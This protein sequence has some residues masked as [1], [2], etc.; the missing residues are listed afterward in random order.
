MTIDTLDALSKTPAFYKLNYIQSLCDRDDP[1]I[2]KEGV[3]RSP[4]HA[5]QFLIL[6]AGLDGAQKKKT[7]IALAAIASEHGFSQRTITQA[8]LDELINQIHWHDLLNP[9]EDNTFTFKLNILLKNKK[10]FCNALNKNCPELAKVIFSDNKILT[11]NEHDQDTLILTTTVKQTEK[12]LHEFEDDVFHKSISYWKVERDENGSLMNLLF[13]LL[14]D[15]TSEFFKLPKDK[16]NKPERFQLSDEL[17]NRIEDMNDGDVCKLNEFVIEKGTGRLA[18]TI[19]ILIKASKDNEYKKNAQNP[20]PVNNGIYASFDNLKDFFGYEQVRITIELKNEA[21]FSKKGASCKQS[22]R[23]TAMDGSCGLA[24]RE[25]SQPTRIIVS[26]VIAN[27]MK[28]GVIVAFNEPRVKRKDLA[29][30]ILDMPTWGKAESFNPNI[31]IN[32]VTKSGGQCIHLL[33]QFP[34][35]VDACRLAFPHSFPDAAHEHSESP[36]SNDARGT[37]DGITTHWTDYENE[38][39]EASTSRHP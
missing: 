15:Q 30:Q 32:L 27:F 14:G 7:V 34:N 10:A 35:P 8:E 11:I 36:I 12:W 22:Q 1:A 23:L 39:N 21:S 26:R 31:F 18:S 3:S 28:A 6:Y 2:E 33:P 20:I 25:D 24:A 9:S 38:A 13:S 4:F 37:D 16:Q 29:G 17:K 5:L 19:E